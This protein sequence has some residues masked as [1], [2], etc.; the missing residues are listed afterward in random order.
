MTI[1]LS[2][3]STPVPI[4][5]RILGF[6]FIYWWDLLEH[7]ELAKAFS[8]CTA[9]VCLVFQSLS[10]EVAVFCFAV[11]VTLYQLVCVC[12]SE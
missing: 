1:V 11:E 5:V 4:H 7:G 9:T 8:H 12:E 2:D 3:E 6:K 10:A